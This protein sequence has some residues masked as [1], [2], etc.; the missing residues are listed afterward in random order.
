[1]NTYQS[2]WRQFTILLLTLVLCWTTVACGGTTSTTQS[3]PTQNANQTR[4]A[5][6][7]LNPGEYGVQQARYSDATG[8]YTLFLLNTPP[9]TPSV[10]NTADLQMAQLTP[11]EVTA[12]KK[13]YLKV[14]N[15]QA[16]LHLTE[17]F[18]I[19]YI[20][21]VTETRPDPQTGEPRTVIVREERGGFWAPFAGALAGNVVGNLLFRPQYYVPPVYQP[22][23]PVMRGYGGYGSTYG[24]AVQTYQ[25]RYQAPPPAVRNR[26]ANF[27][28]TGRIRNNPATQPNSNR[29][30]R[31]NTG[32]RPTG[33]GFGSSTL[34]QSGRSTPSRVNRPSNSGFGSG[35]RSRPSGSRS[36]GS[37]RRR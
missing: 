13:S 6:T 30:L 28:T 31:P 1:M 22:G 16:S 29:S 17:D 12:G 34:R 5:P 36:F 7:R 37:G 32:D 19:E 15:G 23:V 8:E 11:E 24:Q 35:G 21:A 18:K 27:R 2:K 25:S 10:Y 20:H 33:S 26:Q 14:E 9:G 3:S 4:P